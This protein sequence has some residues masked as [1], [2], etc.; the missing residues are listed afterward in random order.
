M[1]ELSLVEPGDELV[2][3]VALYRHRH[4]VLHGYAAPF[5]FFYAAW[6][7]FWFTSLGLNEHWEGGFIGMAAIGIVQVLV[8]LSCYW[9]VHVLA[10]M[11]CAKVR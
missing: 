6:I 5:V 7:Y 10:W 9:S 4:W 3:Y 1:G 2:R 8:C 11:T